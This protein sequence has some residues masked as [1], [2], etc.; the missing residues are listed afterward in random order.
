VKRAYSLIVFMARLPIS[1]LAKI[2]TA[3]YILFLLRKQ[4]QDGRAFF[5]PFKIWVAER[6]HSNAGILDKFEHFDIFR[7][8]FFIS[9]SLMKIQC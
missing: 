8:L 9:I 5:K 7:L 4:F 1:I 6:L 3:L 2:W